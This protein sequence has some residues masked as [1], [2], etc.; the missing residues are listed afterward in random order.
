MA[1]HICRYTIPSYKVILVREASSNN[2]LIVSSPKQTEEVLYEYFKCLDREHFIVL[3]L[4]TKNKVIGINTVSVGTLNNSLIHPR[5]VF[6][7]AIL[8]NAASIIV[9][10]N[11]P[12]GDP[13]PSLDDKNITVK[14]RQ[15]GDII[16]IGVSDHIIVGENRYF[17]FV[18]KGLL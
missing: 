5:E 17:S 7:P 3:M 16:G 2:D 14:I 4:D 12:S 9:A 8:S 6:K 1:K 15:A 10:H 11:H 18:E 13:S